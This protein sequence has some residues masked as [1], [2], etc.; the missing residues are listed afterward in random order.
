MVNHLYKEV[1]NSWVF[2]KSI[3]SGYL[4]AQSVQLQRKSDHFQSWW[5]S[6]WR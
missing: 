3:N 1:S 5:V 2:A 4:A 6:I